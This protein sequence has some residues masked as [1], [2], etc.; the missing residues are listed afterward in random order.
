LKLAKST[1]LVATI[2]MVFDL[3]RETVRVSQM[4]RICT[5]RQLRKLDDSDG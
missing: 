4:V 5:A 3:L 1:S 2:D